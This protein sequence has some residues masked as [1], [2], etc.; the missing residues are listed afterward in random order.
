[1]L[2]KYTR[3]IAHWKVTGIYHRD[4]D[5]DI[6]IDPATGARELNQNQVRSGVIPPWSTERATIV[7]ERELNDK[8]ELTLGGIWGGSPLNGIGYQDI[9]G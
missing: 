6:N 4:F 1:M 9:T 8:L 3:E 7:I 2:Y 5:T